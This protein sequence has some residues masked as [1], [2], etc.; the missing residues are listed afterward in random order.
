VLLLGVRPH[1]DIDH[2]PICPNGPLCPK[3]HPD[4][5][6][7][8]SNPYGDWAIAV[9]QNAHAGSEHRDNAPRLI[10]SDPGDEAFDGLSLPV[11]LC[12]LEQ[13]PDLPTDRS[14]CVRFC[15]WQV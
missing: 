13:R 6:P 4:R 2:G 1:D 7:S 12:G 11:R 8:R 5:E 9:G 15:T 3:R 10:S 14:A